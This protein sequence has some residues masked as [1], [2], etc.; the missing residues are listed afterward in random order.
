ME[1][2]GMT[3]GAY[4]ALRRTWKPGD[5]V[6]IAFDFTGR[7]EGKDEHFALFR[8]PLV[9][10]RDTRFNDGA[11]DQPAKMPDLGQPVAITPVACD[12]KDIWQAFTVMLQTGTD[13]ESAEMKPHPVHF[14]DYASAGNTW[15]ADS[16]YRTW[17]RNPMNM[18]QRPYVSYDVPVK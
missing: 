15:K 7:V 14:C 12:N 8:G 2:S 10:A 17:F 16:L 13:P 4:L 3:P 18:M 11:V 9:L 5:T 1:V 6:E